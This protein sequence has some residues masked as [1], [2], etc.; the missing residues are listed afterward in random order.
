MITSG[1]AGARDRG[2]RRHA[3]RGLRSRADA[4]TAQQL[5][6]HAPLE[7]VILDDEHRERGQALRAG[8]PRRRDGLAA[9]APRKRRLGIGGRLHA[10]L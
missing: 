4:Q 6:S 10:Q 1:G 8:G 7:V 9:R 5:H 2:E 3:V